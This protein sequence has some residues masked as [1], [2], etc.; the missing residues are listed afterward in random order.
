VVSGDNQESDEGE[1]HSE[2]G[3]AGSG[4]GGHG[5]GTGLMMLYCTTWLYR[6]CRLQLVPAGGQGA[7]SDD[8]EDEQADETSGAD[9]GAGK[10][11]YGLYCVK[12]VLMVC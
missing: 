12:L 6:V 10:P 2:G 11:C 1:S 8:G 4:A 7:E 3:Q 5:D 9:D